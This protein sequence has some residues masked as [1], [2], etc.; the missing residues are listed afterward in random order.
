MKSK[1]YT[2][3][4]LYEIIYPVIFCITVITL[5]LYFYFRLQK[6][7]DTVNVAASTPGELFPIPIITLLMLFIILYM[8]CRWIYFNDEGIKYKDLKNNYF[9]PWDQVKYV[10]ITLNN[11]QK[12]G[13]GSYIVIATDSYALQYT[14]F[15]ASRDGFI[16]LKYRLS[17]LDIIKKHY[18]GDIIRAVPEK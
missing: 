16:V 10:K 6:G 13:K 9:I 18:N 4:Y 5:I 17:A 1:K 11:W 12:V 7:S 8:G 3:L 15:R 14:D 2:S